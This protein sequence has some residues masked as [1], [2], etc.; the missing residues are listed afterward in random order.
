MLKKTEGLDEE[1]PAAGARG[2]S[3]PTCSAWCGT[4]RR[5]ERYWFG[6]TLAGSAAWAD[7]D[8]EMELPD[9]LSADE[10]LRDY[11]AAIEDSDAAIAAAG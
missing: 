5:G 8:F 2:Q 10:V 9:S 6:Y 7:V 11:R 4:S 1:Q 3:A